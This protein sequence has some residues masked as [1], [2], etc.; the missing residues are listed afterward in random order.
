MRVQEPGG[1]QLSG[2]AIY[3]GFCGWMCCFSLAI[4]PPQTSPGD[5]QHVQ[6]GNLRLG[7]LKGAGENQ[8]PDVGVASCK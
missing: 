4:F 5:G 3:H 8:A 1:E 7:S 2:I 6:C